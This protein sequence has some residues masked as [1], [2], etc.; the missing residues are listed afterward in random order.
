[1][2]SR[3]DIFFLSSHMR[4]DLLLT[5]TKKATVNRMN[6]KTIFF[7]IVLFFV[8][9]CTGSEVQIY[10]PESES[11]S[12]QFPSRVF[13]TDDVI[14]TDEGMLDFHTVVAQDKGYEYS[15]TYIDYPT[16]LLQTKGSDAI[17]RD[18]SSG[19]VASVSGTLLDRNDIS[20][21]GYSGVSQTVESSNRLFMANIFLVENRLYM[22]VV[23]GL[24]E[25]F[26]TEEAQKFLD[27]FKLLLEE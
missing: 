9:G 4:Q 14:E 1:M 13:E 22:M 17:L 10:S 25:G 5:M 15:I 3:N 8:S 20:I 6:L 21:D 12:A 24:Q 19:A 18:S 16:D 7:I 26:P 27:S 11:F 23:T 2:L